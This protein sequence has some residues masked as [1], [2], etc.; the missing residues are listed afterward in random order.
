[1]QSRPRAEEIA[2]LKE[3]LAALQNAPK[4]TATNLREEIQAAESQRELAQLNAILDGPNEELETKLTN[5]LSE[6]WD[7]VK[8]TYLS[9]TSIPDSEISKACCAVANYLGAASNDELTP[10]SL[11][12]P[13]IE[14][15]L[16]LFSQYDINDVFTLD[17]MIRFCI[18]SDD[19]KSLIPISAATNL[20]LESPNDKLF[21]NP[22]I[23]IAENVVELKEVEE[24]VYNEE[25][26]E[27]DSVIVEKSVPKIKYSRPPLSASEKER[28][29]H[30][31]PEL[32][33]VLATKEKFKTTAANGSTLYQ[34]ISQLIEGLRKG[35]EHGL[36]GGK[37]GDA[38]AAAMEALFTF[39]E[40]WNSLPAETQS[41]ALNTSVEFKKAIQDKICNPAFS[42]CVEILAK[43]LDATINNSIAREVFF[44]IS[45]DAAQVNNLLETSK[46][47]FYLAR[48][49]LHNIVEG[50]VE[51]AYKGRDNLAL[52]LRQI[53]SLVRMDTLK[54]ADD[55]LLIIKDLTPAEIQKIC[56][57]NRDII[58]EVIQDI[59]G[60]IPILLQI[61][62]E[63]AKAF[64]KT[65]ESSLGTTIR[66][67]QDLIANGINLL[68]DDV[69]A[70]LFEVVFNSKKTDA[71]D[72]LKLYVNEIGLS[73]SKLLV[74]KD[75]IANGKIPL[76][77]TSLL[78]FIELMQSKEP[79][80]QLNAFIQEPSV[81]NEIKHYLISPQMAAF[82]AAASPNILNAIHATLGKEFISQVFQELDVIDQ[83]FINFVGD[84]LFVEIF[85]KQFQQH[86]ENFS[87]QS[88]KFDL[89]SPTEILNLLASFQSDNFI[90]V[91]LVKTNLREQL[92]SRIADFSSDDMVKLSGYLSADKQ[93]ELK[94]YLEFHNQ[95]NNANNPTDILNLISNTKLSM[96]KNS[97]ESAKS[98][99]I[100]K[101][102]TMDSLLVILS[103][104]DKH[105]AENFLE[106][107]KK[108]FKT[109]LFGISYDLTT[110]SAFNDDTL[111]ILLDS[112]FLKPNLHDLLHLNTLE[113][114]VS[115][116]SMLK[117]AI[118]A[119]FA[120]PEI[121]AQFISQYNFVNVNFAKQS[122]EILDLIIE[123]LG[124]KT[125]LL[126]KI[127]NNILQGDVLSI[128]Q[129]KYHLN[130]SPPLIMNELMQQLLHNPTYSAKIIDNIWFDT[131][132]EF[133]VFLNHLETPADKYIFFKN[134]DLFSRMPLKSDLNS[135]SIDMLVSAFPAENQESAK[136][137]L[138]NLNKLNQYGNLDVI[139]LKSVLQAYS[140]NPG[141]SAD[142][143]SNLGQNNDFID[144]LRDSFRSLRSSEK[145]SGMSLPAAVAIADLSGDYIYSLVNENN[146]SEFVSQVPG[147]IVAD[148]FNEKLKSAEIEA[149][150]PPESHENSDDEAE[151]E[152]SEEE[153]LQRLLDGDYSPQ[154]SP[155]RPLS[156][157]EKF[158]SELDINGLT[159][160][161]EKFDNDEEALTIFT[162]SQFYKMNPVGNYSTD[163]AIALIA[164]MP[165]TAKNPIYFTLTG[166]HLPAIQINDVQDLYT[167]ETHID[168]N[169]NT[170]Y[171]LSLPS[172]VI[173]ELVTENSSFNALAYGMAKSEVEKLIKSLGG[174]DNLAKI[175][176]SNE[177]AERIRNTLGPDNFDLY[178]EARQHVDSVADVS[179][180]SL[181]H[182]KLGMN[183]TVE[184]AK[185]LEND[186]QPQ[187][188]V[189][190]S[191][192]ISKDEHTPEQQEIK[193]AEESPPRHF[194]R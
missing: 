9:Y 172:S 90:D 71:F 137:A 57:R 18:M 32:E 140:I 190:S 49:L 96:L 69:S 132:D 20:D 37:A 76:V 51:I 151:E 24:Y 156:M 154:V 188:S 6:R 181:L 153:K 155:E 148:Y 126:T 15:T 72:F 36:T 139:D 23:S 184:H 48:T 124:G 120:D 136:E 12:M 131:I 14:H 56:H 74:M 177:E 93:S 147:K 35:G 146:I 10:L 158:I 30:H 47:N 53:E 92:V 94:D 58:S 142:F 164:K 171:V 129:L 119:G 67:P 70:S 108:Q 5:F 138:I 16:D 107:F 183:V 122:P 111:Q 21:E 4:S 64:L 105:K 42:D 180:T 175:I 82:V 127:Q 3:R 145:Y 112:S 106:I 31:S 191:A 117:N 34:A 101:I 144:H 40:Y 104:L 81:A 60:L 86:P 95:L 166:E 54:G 194:K 28:L 160:L 130:N 152:E 43:E 113:V 182:A 80:E 109:E 87:E 88:M 39:R 45:L 25:T 11:L 44:S 41:R 2:T 17:K 61:N 134:L 63:Q 141:F 7:M 115:Q 193:S 157:V 91:L 162:K 99:I 110:F 174:F 149:N 65:I 176:P 179:S 79:S 1:M 128:R 169:L 116:R 59:N 189:K 114:S 143:I 167:Q 100:S 13:T 170:E 168:Y 173:K 123:N 187:A 55:V 98:Q 62:A 85:K 38:G 135:E 50:E 159:K 150:R 186:E 8:G 185:V 89:K 46:N 19:N 165:D 22:Y 178:N 77:K 52:N 192:A 66:L 125:F 73:E 121:R 133:R 97:A 163:E 29:S 78:N 75:L 68:N 27:Y 102:R 84:A 118:E 33:A 103:G 161:L 83:V 26:S